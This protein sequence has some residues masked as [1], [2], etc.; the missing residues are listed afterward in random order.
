MHI[1]SYPHS[2]ESFCSS[3]LRMCSQLLSPAVI[4]DVPP[5][6]R[7]LRFV[8]NILYLDSMH[9][10]GDVIVQPRFRYEEKVEV[11]CVDQMVEIR[12]LVPDATCVHQCCTTC[13]V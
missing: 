10:V 13:D 9:S 5:P 12:N 4:I 6:G 8:R 1:T 3:S 2:S 7:S 11:L